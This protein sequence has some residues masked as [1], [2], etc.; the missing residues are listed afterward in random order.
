MNTLAR[1][2]CGK[3]AWSK[4]RAYYL[5]LAVAGLSEAAE[6]AAHLEAQGAAV[7]QNEHVVSALWPETEGDA[8]EVWDEYLFSELVFWLRAW[9]SNSEP[10]R[11]VTMLEG[12]PVD[13]DERVFLQALSPSSAL[14]RSHL[15]RESRF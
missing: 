7:L 13:V 12:R 1:Q 14:A 5:R 6:L 2:Y 10:N 9:M 3:G 11:D 4:V 15:F 8:P